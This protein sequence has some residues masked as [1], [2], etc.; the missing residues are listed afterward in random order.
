[1]YQSKTVVT[2][3]KCKHKNRNARTQTKM[4]DNRKSAQNGK[5]EQ[6][7]NLN[8]RTKKSLGNTKCVQKWKAWEHFQNQTLNNEK[9]N[10][11]KKKVTSI[12]KA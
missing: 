3:N 6:L 5:S 1:M 8:L 2:V 10:N 9:K 11:K 12:S 7:E 4:H